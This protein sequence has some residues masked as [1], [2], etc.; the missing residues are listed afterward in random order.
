MTASS[1]TTLPAES[2]DASVSRYVDDLF[3]HA[4]GCSRTVHDQFR[5]LHALLGQ[6]DTDP[7]ALAVAL[8]S[9]RAN[10]VL[11][12]LI[13]YE[14]I[15][16][17]FLAQIAPAVIDQARLVEVIAP[18]YETEPLAQLDP[19]EIDRLMRPIFERAGILEDLIPNGARSADRFED[20]ERGQLA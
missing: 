17:K 1:Q 3:R 12:E 15:V 11:D 5:T 14:N 13:H 4:R 6:S 7:H 20:P 2:A 19:E 8:D 10:K 9:R 18:G 16:S